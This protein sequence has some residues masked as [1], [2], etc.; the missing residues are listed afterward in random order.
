MLQRQLCNT[1]GKGHIAIGTADTVVAQGHR[2]IEFLGGACGI[3][4]Y[5]LENRQIPVGIQRVGKGRCFRLIA[6][7]GA[8]VS[9]LCLGVAI[10]VFRDGIGNAIGQI[11]CGYT[12]AVLQCKGSYAIFEGHAAEGSVD[13]IVPQGHGEGK[14]LG[15]VAGIAVHAL[16]DRQITVGIAGVDKPG[17]CRGVLTDGAGIAGLLGYVAIR[18]VVGFRHR[19]ARSAGQVF[20]ELAP[21][22]L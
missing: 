21:A 13:P 7:N 2:E 16:G 10:R 20:N 17:L 12:P 6:H 5:S 4:G 1:V 11:L 18:R 19:V 9:R 8:G 15:F 3:A 22:I 14:L